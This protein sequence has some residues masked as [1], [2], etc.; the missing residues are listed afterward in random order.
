VGIFSRRKHVV[1]V[2]GQVRWEFYQD[3]ASRRWIAICRPLSLTIEADSHTELRENIEDSLRLFMKSIFEDGEFDRFMRDQ[4]WI[5]H[6]VPTNVAANDIR[7]DVPIEL[8]AKA[9]ANGPPRQL[10]Q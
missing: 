6:H 3:Q 4:G 10:H 7:F 5:A 8:I 1:Q 2:E 9:A